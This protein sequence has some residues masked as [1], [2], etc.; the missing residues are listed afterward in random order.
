MT[1]PPSWDRLSCFNRL[2]EFGLTQSQWNKVTVFSSRTA[3]RRP[4]ML[5]HDIRLA[6]VQER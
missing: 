2:S 1:K 6:I 5:K 4:T 3:V